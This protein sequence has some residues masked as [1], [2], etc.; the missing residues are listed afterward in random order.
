MFDLR[1][2]VYLIVSIFHLIL[3]LCSIFL[4]VRTLVDA[5][6]VEDVDVVAVEVELTKITVEEET[7]VEV[8]TVVEA[9]ATT[10]DVVLFFGVPNI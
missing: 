2:C 3:K 8:A 9:T 6:T 4:N 5:N 7:F 10:G 1:V